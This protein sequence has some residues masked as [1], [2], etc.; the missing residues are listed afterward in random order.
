[1]CA[2]NGSTRQEGQGRA[3]I[4]WDWL[5]DFVLR[6]VDTPGNELLF[7][8][9]LLLGILSRLLLVKCLSLVLVL[10]V[11][12]DSAVFSTMLSVPCVLQC[13]GRCLQS[14]T[15]QAAGAA[16]ESS[17]CWRVIDYGCLVL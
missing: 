13:V 5:P 9:V 1:M 8:L 10:I 4:E 12:W 6:P 7:F 15:P 16:W 17:L 2:V 11:V 3:G 14:R